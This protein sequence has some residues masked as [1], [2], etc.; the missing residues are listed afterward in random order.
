MLPCLF[1]GRMLDT[2]RATSPSGS[3]P[4]SPSFRAD[5]HWWR[6]F[7]PHYNG[8]LL[9][10][11]TRHTYDLH[12]TILDNTV[13]V[14]TNTRISTA[15]IPPSIATN[16]HKWAHRECYAVLVALLLW[17][18]TWSEAEVIVHCIDPAKLSVLVHGRSRNEFILDIARQIWF[19]MANNDIQLTPT[20]VQDMPSG[21][22]VSVTPPVVRLGDF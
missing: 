1:V 2:L 7:L 5:L 16:D 3:S 10:Q 14:R 21:E 19:V 22:A 15:P 4:L 20:P 11:L 9:I 12:I 6:D 18:T 13:T 17:G 8:R